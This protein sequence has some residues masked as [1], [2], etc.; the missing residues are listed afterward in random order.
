M[1]Y[2]KCG[3]KNE[4]RNQKNNKQYMANIKTNEENNMYERILEICCKYGMVNKKISLK[5]PAKIL[6]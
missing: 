3:D 6:L 5:T 1:W 2:N 4:R